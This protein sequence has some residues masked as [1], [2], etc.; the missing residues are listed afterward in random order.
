M[1]VLEVKLSSLLITHGYLGHFMLLRRIVR[2]Y[3]AVKKRLSFVVRSYFSGCGNDK[4][5]LFIHK[6]PTMY[7]P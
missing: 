6:S 4:K 5:L 2:F 3:V 7:A 1:L